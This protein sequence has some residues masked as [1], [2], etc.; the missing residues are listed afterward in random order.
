MPVQRPNTVV[1]KVHNQMSFEDGF[2]DVALAPGMGCELVEVEG[3][4]HKTVVP[5]AADSNTTRV[6]REPRNPPQGAE[7]GE[8]VSALTDTIDAGEFTET[9][10]LVSHDE[11]RCRITYEVVDSTTGETAPIEG[12][13]MGWGSDGNLTT[14]A[15]NPVARGIADLSDEFADFDLALVEFY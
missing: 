9:V 12:E 11:A 15:A 5:A 2:A 4:T 7:L 6:V 3:Q 1:A 10:G 8:P 14:A 13:E